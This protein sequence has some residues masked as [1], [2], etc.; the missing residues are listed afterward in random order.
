[1]LYGSLDELHDIGWIEE[2]DD[3][4]RTPPEESDKRRIFRLTAAGRRLLASETEPAGQIWSPRQGAPQAARKAS[5]MTA[6]PRPRFAAR[7]YR[8][9]IAALPRQLVG[10]HGAEMEAMFLAV[11]R[12]GVDRRAG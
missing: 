9:L 12:R 4:R 7:L 3:P 11:P 5:V 10:R 1:M 2:V 8:L 6:R